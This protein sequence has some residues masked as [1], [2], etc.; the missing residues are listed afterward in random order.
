MGNR[1]DVD[2]R[3]KFPRR[4]IRTAASHRKRLWFLTPA[5]QRN[6]SYSLQSYDILKWLGNRTDLAGPAKKLLNRM[7]IVILGSLAE[8]ITVNG[9]R[10]DIGKT[11]RFKKRTR[12]MH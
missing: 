2:A 7:G 4:Y 11:V 6:A 1:K 9:T 5:V 3:V 10:G 12:R 8:A